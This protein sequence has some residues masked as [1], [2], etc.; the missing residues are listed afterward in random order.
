MM[1]VRLANIVK[2]GLLALCMA[3]PSVGT[4]A[5]AQ[6][7]TKP[8]MQQVRIDVVLSRYQGDKKISSLPFTLF[9]TAA[10]TRQ[11]MMN[12]RMG[13][14]VPVGSSTVTRGTATPNNT[15]SESTTSTRVDYRNVGTS[16]DCSVMTMADDPGRYSVYVNVQDS[17]VFTPDTDPKAQLKIS[18]PLA[19][20]TFYVQNTLPVRDGQTVQFVSAADKISGEVLKVEVTLTVMK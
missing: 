12:V 16:I 1:N 14:D 13:V 5:Q 20:R 7:T 2:C 9:G 4:S 15:S 10:S 8:A 17:S 3:M 18:D 6:T 11:G 19:F